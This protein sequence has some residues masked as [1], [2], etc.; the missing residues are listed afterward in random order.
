MTVQG[1]FGWHIVGQRA[2]QARLCPSVHCALGETG[3]TVQAVEGAKGCAV[4]WLCHMNLVVVCPAVCRTV[5]GTGG[6]C[7]Q[8]IVGYVHTC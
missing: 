8:G 5:A 4:L 6:V 3:S 7:S 2:G 1:H